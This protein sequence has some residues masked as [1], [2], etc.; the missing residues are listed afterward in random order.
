M[1]VALEAIHSVHV[2]RVR[3]LR[4]WFGF[5]QKQFARTVGVGRA[6]VVRWEAGAGGPLPRTA[7]GRLVLALREIKS[8]A[9]K[10]FGREAK[11]WFHDRAPTLGGVTPYEALIAR[12]PIPVVMILSANWDGGYL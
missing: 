11:A 5:S 1:A 6:T 2:L 10:A 4:Q 9:I 8:L 3:P 12:G 7:E